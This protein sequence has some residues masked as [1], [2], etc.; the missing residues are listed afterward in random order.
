MLVGEAPYPGPTP[1]AIM[2]GQFPEPVR[3][4]RSVRGTVPEA[5]ECAVVKA[6]A[7]VPADRFATAALFS[8]A[9]SEARLKEA[10]D[11]GAEGKSIA[12]LPF[13]DMSPQKDQEYFCDGMDEELLNALMMIQQVQ[14]ASPTSAFAFKGK[15]QDIRRIG[16]QRCVSMWLK[17]TVR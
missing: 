11:R 13:A 17:G 4:M 7:K 14:D 3:S 16:E 6:L 2:A 8:D 5:L 1:Q 15:N 12:V 9:L 10:A